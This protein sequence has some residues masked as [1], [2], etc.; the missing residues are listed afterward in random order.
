[1]NQKITNKLKFNLLIAS[2]LTMMSNAIIAPALPLI[3][4]TFDYIP[5]AQLLSKLMM[6]LPALTIAI[7]APFTGSLVDQWG[8]LKVLSISL[9]I[10]ALAGTSGAWLNNLYAIL[11]GRVLL[12][13]GVAGTMTA[14]TTLIGDYFKGEQRSAFMGMQSSFI[15][16]GGLL[17]ITSSGYLA[18]LSWHYPFYIY[19]FS[20]VVL[21]LMPF[22]LYEPSIESKNENSD[23]K[24]EYPK[25]TLALVFF[26]TFTAVS[27][28]YIIPVQIPYYI[29]TFDGVSNSESGLAIGFLTMTQ[30]LAALFYRRVKKRFNF[31]SIYAYSFFIQSIG[32]T[33]LY[34]SQ[35][36]VQI[37][38]SILLLGLGT[39]YIFPNA[40]LWMITIIHPRVRGRFVGWLSSFS[41]LGMFFSPLLIQP[42]Q[43]L[44]GIQ[45]SFLAV[46]GFLIILT[47]FYLFISKSKKIK[48]TA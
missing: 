18:D 40:N 35:N 7:L 38:M 12:G 26:S 23:F 27:I 25:L 45:K 39:G 28:F 19:S 37:V 16:L 48:F 34:F 3:T 11:V 8:R 9:V 44:V 15:A 2:M 46:T 29:Q 13:L 22:C 36:F 24:L 10:Y 4:H 33:G 17:F 20:I 1:M 31:A 6:T 43:H 14:A 30:A 42:V 47:F 41:F 32:F 5:N 21:I